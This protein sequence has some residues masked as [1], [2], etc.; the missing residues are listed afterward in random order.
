M[1]HKR[2]AREKVLQALY[3]RDQS[4]DI[5]AFDAD[6]ASILASLD[7]KGRSR[8]YAETLLNGVIENMDELDS[9]IEGSSEN[10]SMERMSI[11]D[12][13]LLRLAAYEIVYCEEVPFR[14]AID[15]AIE[16]AR[17]FG[18]EESWSFINGVLDRIS[19]NGSVAPRVKP[20]RPARDVKD[21]R[22]VRDVKDVR[23]VKAVKDVRAVRFVKLDAAT[24]TASKVVKRVKVVNTPEEK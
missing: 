7:C 16:L 22:A 10:W 19:K 15:E 23:A 17:R 9:L 2:V 4:I 12:K 18:A 24:A 3:Q 14:V 6:T 8:P 20:V 21:V 13:N 11:V 1:R 5:A